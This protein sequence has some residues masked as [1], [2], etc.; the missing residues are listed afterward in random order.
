MTTCTRC[1][2][3]GFLNLHQVDNETLVEYDKT[4][5]RETI[6]KWIKENADHDVCD[7]DCCDGSGEHSPDEKMFISGQ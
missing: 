4:G 3:T 6:E 5:N 2:T 1:E 7:C